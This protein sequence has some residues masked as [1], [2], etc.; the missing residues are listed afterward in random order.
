LPVGINGPIVEVVEN[1][2]DFA[3]WQKKHPRGRPMLPFVSCSSGDW[4]TGKPSKSF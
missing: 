2:V 3:I 1:G 4:L